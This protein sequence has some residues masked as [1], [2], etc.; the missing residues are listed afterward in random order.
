MILLDNILSDIQ[1][2]A[3]VNDKDNF[4]QYDD[5]CMNLWYGIEVEGTRNIQEVVIQN[6]IDAIGLD[7]SDVKSIEH[8]TWP[9]HIKKSS[10][11]WHRNTNIDENGN[12]L[13]EIKPIYSMIYWPLP[14]NIE[15][16]YLEISDARGDKTY[17]VFDKNGARE[18]WNNNILKDYHPNHLETLGD[19]QRIKPVHNRVVVFD[20]DR[21][22]RVAPHKGNRWAMA[23]DFWG[24]DII[25]DQHCRDEIY[26][27]IYEYYK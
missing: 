5:P 15:G 2:Q 24:E 11:K 3:I 10:Y 12:V 22:H 23:I 25:Q 9:N 7:M 1:L 27:E 4:F 18:E 14:L 21:Y 20:G 19:I 16:G 8:W 26:G 13:K 17:E 6:L